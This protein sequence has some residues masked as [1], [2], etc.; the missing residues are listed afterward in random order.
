MNLRTIAAV[1]LADFRD[2]SR[3]YVFLVTVVITLYLGYLFV[4]PVG[5]KFYYT[6]TA[7]YYRGYYNAAWVGTAAAMA[8]VSLLML[9]GFYAIKNAI[10]RDERH[11][12]GEL[13]AA[14]PLSKFEYVTGKF[15]S[16]V[17]YL[18]TVTCLLLIMSFVMLLLRGEDPDIHILPLIEP[19]LF[20]A[21]PA[22][23][24]FAAFAVFFEV[25]P[26][27]RGGLGNV[28]YFFLIVGTLPLFVETHT[29]LDV[30][31][32]EI[33]EQE[34]KADIVKSVPEYEGGFSL[35]HMGR[36][37]PE[38]SF[39]WSGIN[40]T[41]SRITGRLFWV[42]LGLL[43]LILATPA[44][45]RFDPARGSPIGPAGAGRLTSIS[46]G[47]RT[48]LTIAARPM[49]VL[50]ETFRFGRMIA[51]ELRIALLG[52]PAIWYLV[53]AGLWIATL[54]SPLQIARQHIMPFAWIWPILI[55]SQIGV[56]E[57]RHRVD[58]L[59][60]SMP[61]PGLWQPL[62][63][64]VAGFA[65]AL[66]T[67]SGLLIR[68]AAAGHWSLFSALLAGAIFIPSLAFA[69]GVISKSSRLFEVTYLILWY[70]GPMNQVHELDYMGTYEQSIQIGI[71]VVYLAL[72]PAL[73]ITAL[74]VRSRQTRA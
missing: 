68:S 28:I 48:A 70:I 42:G 65:V 9:V 14:A 23:I 24:F 69:C 61:D 26:V 30:M 46:G 37:M 60:F 5:E 27:L 15:L 12:V 36:P 6:L 22:V 18:G 50:L 7:G 67:G 4:P 44:F 29:G 43:F 51:A 59:I 34:I 35:G 19:F 41:P 72:G 66:L 57:S 74:L 62:A 20:I 54:L 73:L 16:N 38:G 33:A 8:G 63:V 58:Q 13:L 53:A 17:Y 21:L 45:T 52:L 40:W 47:I 49:S 55:W 3:S 1:G 25:F 31:G 39:Y 10:K 11:R 2:R 56:R 71:P 64:W 32:V